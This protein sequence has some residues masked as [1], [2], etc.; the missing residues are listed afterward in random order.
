MWYKGVIV[1]M[2][3]SKRLINYKG[4][5]SCITII[6]SRTKDVW[7]EV[8]HTMD[9]LLDIMNVPSLAD[10][11]LQLKLSLLYKILITWVSLFFFCFK[12]FGNRHFIHYTMAPISENTGNATTTRVVG[13]LAIY[14]KKVMELHLVC[15]PKLS[16]YLYIQQWKGGVKW[17]EKIAENFFIHRT[18]T[19]NMK[20]I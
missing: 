17:R 16:S 18:K 19:V 11:R 10:H 1:S 7:G 14:R 4:V 15:G 8:A 20:R 13:C 3:V 12:R 5:V 2:Y 9:D 6:T